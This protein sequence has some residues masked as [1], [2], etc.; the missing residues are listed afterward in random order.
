MLFKFNERKSRVKCL[1]VNYSVPLMVGF[2]LVPKNLVL[3][4]LML[5]SGEVSLLVQGLT[6]SKR[7]N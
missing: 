7:Q 5:K 1:C 3:F 2:L 4:I 6:A